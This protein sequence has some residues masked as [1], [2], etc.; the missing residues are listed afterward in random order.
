MRRNLETTYL[1]ILFL[2]CS[3]YLTLP[4]LKQQNS[5]IPTIP[6]NAPSLIETEG[7][8]ERVYTEEFAENHPLGLDDVDERPPSELICEWTSPASSGQA[9]LICYVKHGCILVPMQEATSTAPY[10]AKVILFGGQSMLKDAGVSQ[11]NVYPADPVHMTLGHYDAGVTFETAVNVSTF[12]RNISANSLPRERKGRYT[13][14][15]YFAAGSWGHMLADNFFGMWSRFR[16]LSRLI[17]GRSR[18]VASKS[19]DPNTTHTVLSMKNCKTSHPEDQPHTSHIAIPACERHV[20]ELS[21]AVGVTVMPLPQGTTTC[22][23]HLVIGSPDHLARIWHANA[24][25]VEDF[26]DHIVRWKGRDPNAAAK[27]NTTVLVKKNSEDSY[28]YY[29]FTNEA[30]LVKMLLRVHG[31]NLE[32]REFTSETSFEEQLDVLLDTKTLISPGGGIGFCSFFLAKG[33]HLVIWP[34][35][36][37]SRAEEIQFKKSEKWLRTVDIWKPTI[38]TALP[39]DQGG[40]LPHVIYPS[41]YPIEEIERML[42][43]EMSCEKPQR[44]YEERFGNQ[45]TPSKRS[46]EKY[47][48]TGLDLPQVAN[49]CVDRKT[50]TRFLTRKSTCVPKE[51]VTYIKSFLRCM[52]D[53]K[54][55]FYTDRGIS[56]FLDDYTAH[57]DLE[58]MKLAVSK[59][60]RA[61][62]NRSLKLAEMSRPLLLERFG[63]MMFDLD[64]ECTASWQPILQ[65]FDALFVLEPFDGSGGGIYKLFDSGKI[66]EIPWDLAAFNSN[67]N[68]LSSVMAAGK[69]R[70]ACF[71]E[72]AHFM[73]Q[74]INRDDFDVDANPVL[75][76]GPVFHYK[77]LEHW[78]SSKPSKE[79]GAV[80]ASYLLH[81][82]NCSACLGVHHGECTWCNEFYEPK[83]EDCVD[84]RDILPA[85]RLTIID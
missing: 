51:K 2:V 21:S 14:A 55:A 71:K 85:E 80:L 50:Y 56:K 57:S 11:G 20:A 64:V 7:V 65:E 3:A 30:D 26:R 12:L 15:S 61:N 29:N 39:L 25:D 47:I 46:W 36:H 33:S 76:I 32:I 79:A 74:T 58:G 16:F 41:A 70:S 9:Q 81:F 78:F 6:P 18:Q 62:I 10:I 53:L 24:S 84:I 45:V 17:D 54:F 28:S 77:F 75:N 69:P 38:S 4:T 82:R 42:R 13:L 34:Y 37:P 31:T 23:E 43:K 1:A 67:V 40:P 27:S 5:R 8:A 73:V 83:G 60:R 68:V 66:S 19:W 72:L 63:G 44:V 48:L 49:T 35:E 59:M 52:P 22:Y